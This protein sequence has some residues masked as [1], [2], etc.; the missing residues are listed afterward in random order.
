MIIISEMKLHKNAQLFVYNYNYI[1][2]ADRLFLCYV[3]V[4]KLS[5]LRKFK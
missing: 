3:K 5:N 1:K 4:H 2:A